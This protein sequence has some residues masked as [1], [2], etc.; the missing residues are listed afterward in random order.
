M[1]DK[2]TLKAK[3]FSDM[4]SIVASDWA[5]TTI[6]SH[7]RNAPLY[8]MSKSAQNLLELIVEDKMKSLYETLKEYYND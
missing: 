5:K 2:H 8:G 3:A 1:I 6:I 4:Y 7:F